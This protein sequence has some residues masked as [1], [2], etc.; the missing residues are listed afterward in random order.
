VTRSGASSLD[1]FNFLPSLTEV[2]E[3]ELADY[4]QVGTGGLAETLGFGSALGDGPTEAGSEINY[5]S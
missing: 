3:R 2:L 1:S 4:R 5:Q